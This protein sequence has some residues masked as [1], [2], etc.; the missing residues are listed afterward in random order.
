VPEVII[1]DGLTNEDTLAKIKKTL[2]WLLANL[3]HENVRRLY[4]EY[5]QIS[6]AEGETQISGPLLLMYDK[7]GTPVLRVKMGYDKDTNDFVHQLMNASGNI[8]YSV[9]S[10]GDLIVERGTFKG[11]ITIG[12]GNDIIKADPASGFWIGHADYASAP[13]KVAMDGSAIA[14]NL[15]VIGGTIKTADDGNNRIVFDGAGLTSYNDDD[16]KS[17]LAV[18]IGDYGYS[19]VLLY[20]HDLPVGGYQY[21]SLG[22]FTYF[23]S[24]GVNM[25]IIPDGPD[26]RIFGHWD[27]I[28]AAFINLSDGVNRY[29]TEDFVTSQGYI[30]G[31]SGAS[32]TFTSQDGKTI[33]VS[34]GLITSI[35]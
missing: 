21:D 8:T 30:T 34:N 32:G 20:A 15:T 22:V 23:T 3:D 2:T 4:T 13:F 27:C 28:N 1:K 29:A 26:N 14:T 5:C 11:K 12:T 9:D 25:Y 17:G 35:T 7:Q 19:K 6:S 24:S 10:N 31:T 33:T 16:E 18:E